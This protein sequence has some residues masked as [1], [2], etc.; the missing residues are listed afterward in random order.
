MGTMAVTLFGIS[1]AARA[2]GCSEVMLRAF[3]RRG[4][5]RPM[6]DSAGRRLYTPA[7]IDVI[8]RHR[9]LHPPGRPRKAAR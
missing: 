3:E 5:V 2:A 8:Q 1:A 9:A 7:D 4:V 6:R